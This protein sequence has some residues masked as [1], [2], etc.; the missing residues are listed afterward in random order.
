MDSGGEGMLRSL[1]TFT[2]RF[3]LAAMSEVVARSVLLCLT[4]GEGVVV[5]L[6]SVMRSSFRKILQSNLLG[7]ANEI[8][9]EN[10]AGEKKDTMAP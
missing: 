9:T 8:A 7:L 3:S 6:F 2:A 4:D 5:L 1:E 10:M